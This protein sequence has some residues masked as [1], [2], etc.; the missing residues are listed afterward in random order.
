MTTQMR[1]ARTK[2]A[3]AAIAFAVVCIG[4]PASAGA[5]KDVHTPSTEH[6][7]N[8]TKLVQKASTVIEQK[9]GINVLKISKCGPAKRKGKLD[10]SRW[11]CLWRAEGVYPGQV[12]YTCKGKA[13]WRRK[14]NRWIVDPCKNQMQP[15]APLLDVPNPHPAFGFN[16]DWIFVPNSALDLLDDTGSTVARTGLTWS[17][18]EGVQGSYNWYGVDQL[19][20]KLRARGIKPLWS[21]LAAPCWAQPDPGA[22]SGGNDQL[23]PSQ[24]HYDEMAAF[25]VA[26]AKRYPESAGIEVWNEPNYPRFWGGW[27]E[28]ELYA[29][30]LKTTAAAL[31]S[32]VPGMPVVSGG[33][34]PHSDSD[35]HAIGF[36][37][38]LERL[39]ELGAA[40]EAD[41]IGIHPYPGV[42]PNEDY[43]ADVR[44]YLG[45]IQNVM[46]KFNDSSTGMWATE[47]GVSTAG[48]HAFDPG[49][50]GRAMA[51]IYDVLRRVNRVDLAIIHRFVEHPELAG[52]EAGFGVVTQNLAP[53]PIFCGE[54]F[55]MRE[56]APDGPCN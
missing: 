33:L 26:A 12:P 56:L 19:Y 9:N 55:A 28:P 3:A 38:F 53:K 29:K 45:K 34:S 24:A 25:A 1:K 2:F 46:Q 13:S 27:P 17:G 8:R 30:M 23:R 6:G 18:I 37:N 39:Y 32:Q 14:G 50:Q 21:I 43:V 51:E 40:Q 4:T 42:G 44:I 47:F 20:A 54:L 31:H 48:E 11:I 35:K 16:D 10:Y 22:C 52:R 5:N 49:Q 41:A 7:V 36:S 15:L